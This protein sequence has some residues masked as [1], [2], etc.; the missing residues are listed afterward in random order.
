MPARKRGVQPCTLLP[1]AESA[2]SAASMRQAADRT[3]GSM[4]APPAVRAHR[5]LI[6][7]KRVALAS[8]EH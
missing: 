3:S 6:E 5:V 2:S 4:R 8:H 1:S 7:W